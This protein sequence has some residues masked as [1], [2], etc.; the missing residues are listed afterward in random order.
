MRAAEAFLLSLRRKLPCCA[1]KFFRNH[2]RNDSTLGTIDTRE[3]TAI[4]ANHQG[5]RAKVVQLIDARPD[6]TAYPIATGIRRGS[7]R[8]S[9]VHPTPLRAGEK[10]CATYR[11]RPCRGYDSS[12][13]I[14]CRYISPEAAFRCSTETLTPRKDQPAQMSLLPPKR[15]GIHA[16]NPPKFGCLF[17]GS[18]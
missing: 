4:V 11:S 3:G 13:G 10:I 6:G 5:C 2:S 9:D 1:G 14:H 18:C 15:S 17:S 7:F 12:M 16:R 8:D